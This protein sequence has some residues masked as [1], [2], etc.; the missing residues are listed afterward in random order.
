[1]DNPKRELT[2]KDGS[3]AKKSKVETMEVKFMLSINEAV[4][5]RASHGNVDATPVP[6]IGDAQPEERSEATY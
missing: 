3:A 6:K 1:M 4:G 2:S 5:E